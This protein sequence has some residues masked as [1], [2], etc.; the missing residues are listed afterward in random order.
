MPILFGNPYIE[1]PES[2]NT[3]M[4]INKEKTVRISAN[5][6]R[7]SYKLL[8]MFD[9]RRPTFQF[10]I[11]RHPYTLMKSAYHYYGQ[12]NSVYCFKN[13]KNFA[14]FVDRYDELS[15]KDREFNT[16]WDRIRNKNM[17]SPQCQNLLSYDLGHRDRR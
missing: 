3:R 1:Y 11:I 13:S 15:R 2:F 9:K 8:N 16:V 5:H 10:T 14:D 12:Q 7:P 17:N 4:V 6:L